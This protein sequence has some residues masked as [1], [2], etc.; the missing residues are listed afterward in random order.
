MSVTGSELLNRIFRAADAQPSRVGCDLIL[1]HG[2][3]CGLHQGHPPPCF[4][5]PVDE[6]DTWPYPF[7]EAKLGDERNVRQSGGN[8]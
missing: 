3:V 7:S 6:S 4:P 1:D 2:Y 5:L 8:T